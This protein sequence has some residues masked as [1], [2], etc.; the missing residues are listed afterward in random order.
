MLSQNTNSDK[1]TTM[2]EKYAP[3]AVFAYNRVEKV[4]NCIE[5]LEK[6]QEATDSDLIIFCDGAKGDKDKADV[7][8][9]HAFAK[10]YAQK[11]TFKSVKPVIQEKNRGLAASIMTGVTEVINEYGRAIVVEDDLLVMPSFLK[12]M[13]EGLDYYQDDRKCGSICSFSYPMKQLENYDKD[14]YFTWKADCWGWATWADRWNNAEWADTDFVSYLNDMRLRRQF[15][16]LEA[17]LDRLMYLQYKR[18]IDSW[19]V[20]WIYYLFRKGQLSVYPTKS[21]VI[22]DG[23]DGTGTH[24]SNG[25]GEGFNSEYEDVITEF[26]WEKCEYNEELAKACARFPRR[27]LPLYVLETLRFMMRKR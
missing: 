16:G 3:V 11:R 19:A 25:F 1:I 18:K 27:F 14:V 22:N 12:Y 15:E 6:C 5:Y 20:R 10:D 21:Q 7:E 17:G 26:S 2:A 23:F 4:K 8:K 9:V 24:I 13:N